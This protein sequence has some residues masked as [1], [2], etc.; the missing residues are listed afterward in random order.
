MSD[1]NDDDKKKLAEQLEQFGNQQRDFV[2]NS[3]QQMLRMLADNV[4]Q[5]VRPYEHD[6]WAREWVAMAKRAAADLRRAEVH[7]Q[8]QPFAPHGE[9]PS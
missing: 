5:I 4:V 7:V 9:V 3:I 8:V 1:V 6:E 2:V